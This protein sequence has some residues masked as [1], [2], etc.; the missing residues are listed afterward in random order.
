MR[1]EEVRPARLGGC[2][3]SLQVGKSEEEQCEGFGNVWSSP[4]LEVKLGSQHQ[5]GILG[6][7]TG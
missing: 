1:G 4:G 3:C 7:V 5:D 2:W 6:D